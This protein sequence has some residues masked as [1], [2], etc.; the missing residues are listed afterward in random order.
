MLLHITWHVLS[1]SCAVA[2]A[3]VLAC[4][5]VNK[6]SALRMVK[7]LLTCAGKGLTADCDACR[8]PSARPTPPPSSEL[9]LPGS[10]THLEC[11]HTS[12]LEEPTCA[13]TRVLRSSHTGSLCSRLASNPASLHHLCSWLRYHQLPHTLPQS[14]SACITFCSSLMSFI[15]QACPGYCPRRVTGFWQVC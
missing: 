2:A 8:T 13:A 1:G 6:R 9:P 15:G 12:S 5:A 4:S 14:H 7:G 10:R 3:T 11:P